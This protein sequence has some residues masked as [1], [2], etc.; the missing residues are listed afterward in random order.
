[1]KKEE[2]VAKIKALLASSFLFS[3][4]E[5]SAH[6]DTS[7][8][9]EPFNLDAISMTYFYIMVQET[10]KCELQSDDIE[11]CRPTSINA[12]ASMVSE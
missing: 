7:L 1:M 8:F 11:R 2:A 9:L 12:I 4:S 5:I 10:L 3:E 6:L